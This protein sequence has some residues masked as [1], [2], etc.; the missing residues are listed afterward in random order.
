MPGER[1]GTFLL[2]AVLRL[3]SAQ[4]VSLQANYRRLHCLAYPE[5]KPPMLESMG[6]TAEP[7]PT[8][9]ALDHGLLRLAR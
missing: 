8:S 7:E 1:R 9:S 6:D 4:P 3:R 5:S 2:C